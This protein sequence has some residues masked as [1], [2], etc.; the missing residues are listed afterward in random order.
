VTLRL[1]VGVRRHPA[2]SGSL[3][4][5]AL[6]VVAHVGSQ[7]G[8]EVNPVALRDDG[9]KWRGRPH[10]VWVTSRRIGWPVAGQVDSA[11]ASVPKMTV[12]NRVSVAHQ[13]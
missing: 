3:G 5:E 12:K 1:P 4:G 13:V 10:R 11:T 6:A 9:S 2:A 8:D 7:I